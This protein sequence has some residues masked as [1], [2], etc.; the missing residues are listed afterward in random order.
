MIELRI[1][2]PLDNNFGKYYLNTATKII[3]HAAVYSK[4]DL[5]FAERSAGDKLSYPNCKAF[6]NSS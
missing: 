5:C 1:V 6:M 3:T 2:K 4:E